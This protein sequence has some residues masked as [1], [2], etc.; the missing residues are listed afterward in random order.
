M[1]TPIIG[2]KRCTKCGE[3]KEANEFWIRKSRAKNG[4]SGTLTSW[5]KKCTY[6]NSILWKNKNPHKLHKIVPI[7]DAA[8]NCKNGHTSL[9]NKHG[10]CVECIR[11]NTRRWQAKN[12]KHCAEYSR[13]WRKNNPEKYIAL[14]NNCNEKRR[15]ASEAEKDIIR[16]R[17][18]E[19]QKNNPDIIRRINRV[20]MAFKR[21]S[22]PKWANKKLIARIYNKCPK[23][24]QVDHIIPTKGKNVC[25]LHVETNLQYLPP[26]ENMEKLNS[27][28]GTEFNGGSPV[29]SAP[30]WINKAS[31]KPTRVLYDP[32]NG[33]L[34][35]PMLGHLM[36]GNFINVY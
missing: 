24:M 18:R 12:S 10:H 6:K 15:N 33:S 19:W 28:D 16:K 17:N 3:E 9:R 5:C 26:K 7:S 11:E 30:T 14:K 36:A 1:S 8:Y 23:G 2:I 4:G 27:F 20:R 35:K 22:A 13:Q 34:I 21:N 25:G 31:L 32:R 29:L